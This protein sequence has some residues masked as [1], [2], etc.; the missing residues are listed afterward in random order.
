MCDN[1][2]KINF[3]FL[4]K[5]LYRKG[6]DHNINQW[7]SKYVERISSTLIRK[8]YSKLILFHAFSQVLGK[9]K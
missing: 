8:F 1:V 9:Q 2:D 3:Y 7:K 4:L 6:I 5:T